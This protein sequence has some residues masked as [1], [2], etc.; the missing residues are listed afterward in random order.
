MPCRST[1]TSS[2]RPPA[3]TRLVHVSSTIV[4]RR[5][6]KNAPRTELGDDEWRCHSVVKR[7]TC[8]FGAVERRHLCIACSDDLRASVARR[9][10]VRI[11]YTCCRKGLLDGAIRFPNSLCYC[12]EFFISFAQGTQPA[13]RLPSRRAGGKSETVA[14]T[15]N[16]KRTVN[17]PPVTFGVPGRL[18]CTVAHL[19]IHCSPLPTLRNSVECVAA[20]CEAVCRARYGE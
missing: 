20:C 14:T 10:S 9:S 8:K 17:C 4:T 5:E 2:F 12:F 19:L 11:I 7:P 6:A 16:A 3:R 13:A 18:T 1:K 15:C